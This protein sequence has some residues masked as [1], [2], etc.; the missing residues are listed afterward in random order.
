MKKMMVFATF[1]ITAVFAAWAERPRA[2]LNGLEQNA[3]TLAIPG[4]SW[5]IE[6]NLPPGFVVEGSEISSDG[7]RA[8]LAGNNQS[9]GLVLSLFLEK[10][11]TEG[12]AKAAR[13]YYWKRMQASPFKMEDVQLSERDGAAVLE[14]TVNGA[15]QK[16]IDWKNMH[17]YLSHDGYWVDVHI[18]KIFYRSTDRVSFDQILNS[19]KIASSQLDPKAKVKPPKPYSVSLPQHGKL[20]LTIPASWKRSVK[21]VTGNLPPTIILS[22][23]KGDAFETLITPI[24]S[25]ENDPN[26]NKAPALKW[27]IEQILKKM[28]PTAVEKEVAIQEIN[29]IDGP[30]HYFLV[31]D[32]APKPGEYPYAVFAMVGVGDLILAVTILCRDKDSEGIA[33]TIRILQEA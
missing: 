23:K 4:K 27:A 22:P 8:R 9:T 16:K 29:G 24:W 12:N 2:L 32:K 30:G 3:Y 5:S 31:T 28:L 10:A 25:P 6:I 33:A 13:E 18:S 1:L 26:F 20:I 17:L 7:E 14:Y 11:A 21:K 19:V 15:N